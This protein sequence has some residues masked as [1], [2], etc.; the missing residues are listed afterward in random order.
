MAIPFQ[1]P[2][3]GRVTLVYVD[4]PAWTALSERVPE[5]AVA[6]LDLL[7]REVR[8][9]LLR[10][11]GHGVRIDGPTQLLVWSKPAG[12]LEFALA[13]QEHLLDLHWPLA[14]LEQPEAAVE[15][16]DD[17]E[18]VHR[19][20]RVRVALH[21]GHPR[22]RWDADRR[23]RV[24]S[25]PAVSH[26]ARVARAANSGQVL[27][28][29]AAWSEVESV[30]SDERMRVH[31]LGAHRL[32]G[33]HGTETLVEV[34]PLALAGRT[35]GSPI[36]LDSRRSNL[37]LDERA[38]VGRTG[39]RDGLLSL[40]EWG[41]RL[42]TIVGPA[43]S[44]RSRLAREVAAQSLDSW[45]QDG[46]VW[47]CDITCATSLDDALRILG[48]VLEVPLTEGRS[49]AEL[50]RQL[51]YALGARGPAL[52]VLVGAD[53]TR[54]PL[55]AAVATWVGQGEELSFLV[56]SDAP[57]GSPGEVVWDLGPLSLPDDGDSDA[58][59]CFAEVARRVR[60]AWRVNDAELAPI[61]EMVRLL[62][63]APLAICLVASRMAALS[64]DEMLRGLR[65]RLPTW[66]PGEVSPLSVGV[67]TALEWSWDQLSF[68]ERDTLAQ[69][70]VFRGGWDLES[71]E[72]VV[73]LS[74]HLSAP[75]VGDVV[76][77]LVE[78][79]LIESS[80]PAEAPGM[81]RFSLS[82]SVLAH[83]ERRLATVDRDAAHARHRSW[84]LELGAEWSHEAYRRGSAEA[85]A[86]LELEFFNIVAAHERA[87]ASAPLTSSAVDHALA[88]VLCL[89]PL[90]LAWGPSSKAIPLVD[91]AL[92]AADVVGVGDETLRVRALRF[93]AAAR[94]AR[95]RTDD[96]RQDLEM[97]RIVARSD[98]LP[99]EEAATLSALGNLHRQL[100]QLDQAGTDLE[101]A[102]ELVMDSDQ[103][104]LDG[105]IRGRLSA[106]HLQR[107]DLA[108]AELLGQEA[109]ARLEDAGDY[110]TMATFLGNLGVIA[111][112]RGDLES[113][114][115]RY[116]R[117]LEAHRR[118]GNR[119]LESVMLGNM[120]ALAYHRGRLEVARSCYRRALVLA[121]EVGSS[122]SVGTNRANLG[123][124]HLELG[125]F[126]RAEVHFEAALAIHRDAGHTVS[127]GV[128]QGYLGVL[129]HHMGETDASRLAYHDAIDTLAGAAE[130]RFRGIFQAW[131][132]ALEL[133]DG[134]LDVAETL[135]ERAR[136][137]LVD[138]EDPHL[139][140]AVE[141]LACAGDVKG[142]PGAQA[143]LTDRV[144][145]AL[146]APAGDVLH[147]ADVRVVARF[148][149]RELGVL[150]PSMSEEGDSEE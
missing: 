97:A 14:L 149:A 32:A 130:P 64:P 52:V 54:G 90:L 36:T 101:R 53:R 75:W 124:V 150:G 123:L 141:L 104:R 129:A 59:A 81:L 10:H 73:D 131:A 85:M 31:A 128:L 28:S 65:T 116:A 121:R 39:E 78:R 135:L 58:V 5:S 74:E 20:L 147:S 99:D 91:Q 66:Q 37:S 33:Q 46:G 60:P 8:K 17:D 34:R 47:I 50:I 77:G 82:P 122:R 21:T 119:R 143:V 23:L 109:V 134:Q 76:H 67:R 24:Y 92:D 3:S 140:A 96:A 139:M 118:T 2:P 145:Q 26:V 98:A 41:A 115:H 93:R 70:T 127:R 6:A 11:G 62:G 13:L 69:L 40:L 89:E 108:V 42:C 87:L 56:T 19:G 48:S 125:E 113:A 117:A 38:I 138:A 4:V 18:V 102:L 1:P 35:Y 25:G 86:R 105:E 49:A 79:S 110:G 94:L 146:S 30:V 133:G 45:G 44:G 100:G 88:L 107:G 148:L 15:R 95:G 84:Y 137:T 120:G 29:G 126:H 144:Q 16:G 114:E 61:Q 142:T 112:R 57:L 68:W 72:S 136:D 111:R 43:G 51:G 22:T 106:L 103:P 9:L 63:G 27:L 7:E 71:A 55:G 132:G 80:E 83:A 12:A